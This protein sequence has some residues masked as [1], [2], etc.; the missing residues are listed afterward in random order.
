MILPDRL[1]H[2]FAIDLETTTNGYEGS[3]KA[4]YSCN[5]VLTLGASYDARACYEYK[6]PKNLVDYIT[7]LTVRGLDLPIIVAHNLQFDLGYLMRDY[8]DLPWQTYNLWCTSVAEYIISGHRTLYPSLVDTAA[9]YGIP[10]KKAL[11]LEAWLKGGCK[12]EDIA[13]E[14][15][16]KYA[17]E[18]AIIA[19]KIYYKQIKYIRDTFGHRS[20]KILRLILD[21]SAVIPAICSIELNGMQLDTDKAAKA[22]IAVDATLIGIVTDLRT[23]LTRRYPTQVSAIRKLNLT[24]NRTVSAVLFGVPSTIE[25]GIKKKDKEDMYFPTAIYPIG[26]AAANPK[27][28]L[29]VA[30]EVLRDKSDT[31][32]KLIKNYRSISKLSSTYY[33]PL[34]DRAAFDV[35]GSVHTNIHTTSTHTGRT[36]SSSPNFQN[37]PES[38]RELFHGGWDTIYEIDFKQLELCSIA[39]LSGDEQLIKDI[40]DGVDVH[41]EIGK[42]VFGWTST[43]SMTSHTRRT[44]KT[45]VFGLCYG[46]GART[47]AL[48]ADVETTVALCVIEA[49]YNRY[50]GVKSWHGSTIIEAERDCYAPKPY[51]A[52]PDGALKLRT[53]LSIEKTGRR[54]VFEQSQSP[55][56]MRAKTPW[57]FSPTKLKNYRAQGFAGGDIVLNFLRVLYHLLGGELSAV[58]LRNMIHDSIVATV[59]TGTEELFNKSVVQAKLYIERYYNLSV[60]LTVDI[61]S[62]GKYW[63]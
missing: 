57:S 7:D 29:S 35:T 53:V 63:S 32:S 16:H 39:E 2:A 31:Y 13:P 59:P 44:V 4:C 5:R 37:M 47:L 6:E 33:A 26:T 41:Y 19:N 50:P 46:G 25:V 21:Q 11:D 40:K 17:E 51:E 48:Q 9:G 14:I 43:S 24:A 3:P 62:S 27:L 18:D 1:E 23:E 10:Y 38:V 28:G 49:F 22:L 42:L 61:K 56:W 52:H 8:P 58:R 55:E 34:L 15:L 45:I 54:F 36:S 30:E 12:M 20:D 60:P